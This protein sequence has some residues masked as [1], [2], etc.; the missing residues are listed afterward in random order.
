LS[1]AALCTAA[2]EKIYFGRSTRAN[3]TQDKP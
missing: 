1:A 2:L 3:I